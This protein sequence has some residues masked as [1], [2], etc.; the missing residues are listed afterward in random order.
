MD[1]VISP[2]YNPHEYP[3]YHNINYTI[4]DTVGNYL[5]EESK[6]KIS[7]FKLN[8]KLTNNY[9]IKSTNQKTYFKSYGREKNAKSNW[10]IIKL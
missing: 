3:M 7:Q 5:K 4:I 8:S 2:K 6:N 10:A 1:D 9:R